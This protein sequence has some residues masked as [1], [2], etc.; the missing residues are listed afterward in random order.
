MRSFFKIFL[1]SLLALLVFVFIF[2]FFTVGYISSAVS[3][4]A[5]AQN[6]ETGSSAVLVLDLGQA[7]G[8]KPEA[9]PLVGFSDNRYN[10]PGVYDVI[11]MIR[12]AQT[13]SSIRGIYIKCNSNEN[14]LATSEEIRN[15]LLEFK[16]SGKFLYAYGDVISLKAY[17]V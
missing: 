7:F 6:V 13:D 4:F 12:Y 16:K 15:A 17:Y 1:A 10:T 3:G 5:K 2:F 14:G 9:D 8:E 11:R